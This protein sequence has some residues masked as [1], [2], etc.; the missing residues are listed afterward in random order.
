M[1]PL[2][3]TRHIASRSYSSIHA[4]TAETKIE[5]GSDTAK[6]LP[7][8]AIPIDGRITEF[9]TVLLRDAC[10]CPLCVH[11]ST[12]QRLFSAADIPSNIQTQSVEVNN[13]S[14]SVNIKWTTDVP[15]YPDNHSTEISIEDLRVLQ[16]T[17]SFP[18]LRKDSLPPRAFWNEELDLPNYNYQSYMKDDKTLYKLIYQL[19]KDG[20]AFL[21]NVPGTQEALATIATRIGP[22]KDTFY[23]YT[24]DVRTVPAAINAAYTS[25]DLG[26]HTDLLYF[27]QPPHI[28]LLHCVQSASSG[29]ASVFADAYKAALE[30]FRTDVEAFETL[31]TVPVNYHYNHPDSNV[32][33]TTKPVIDL[34]TLRLGD[35]IYTQSMMIDF[36]D[37]INW[38]PPFLAPFPNSNTFIRQGNTK[39]TVVSALN[40][41]VDRWHQA[42]SK[43]NALLQRPEY[44][45]ER[46]MKPGECVLFDNTRT[47]HS[48]RAFDMADVGKPRWLRGTYVDKDP[49]FS[50]MRVLQNTFQ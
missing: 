45:Y 25:H 6:L 38:G 18:E 16:R 24:W 20:L 26:F 46:K 48:R 41:K 34:R 21:T 44:Q 15:G 31:A 11:E 40:N 43:F 39:Q 3:L 7:R 49:F 2:R 14:D 27:E 17:G 50:K 19:H 32:Y 23:G 37:K 8:V 1:I 42:A 30:L 47:L 10:S 33:R 36:M 28:Q 22:V 12:R 4:A 9:S 13:S 35:T 5:Q 29:G